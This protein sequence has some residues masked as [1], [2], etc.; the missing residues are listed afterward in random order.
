MN[1][2]LSD[3]YAV[4]LELARTPAFPQGSAARGYILH[5][6]VGRA[7]VIDGEAIR[8][9]S[10]RAIVRR[11]WPN[12]PELVG[13]LIPTGGDWAFSYR[14]GPDDDEMLARLANHPISAGNYL[15]ITEADGDVC[16]YR[17]AEMKLI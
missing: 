1:E 10:S 8:K 2:H 4:R 15:T 3:W 13:Q 16:P 14:D 5:L 7:G 12:E 11:F 6:P 9:T 17:I